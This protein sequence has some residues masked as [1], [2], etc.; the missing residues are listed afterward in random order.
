V[1]QLRLRRAS[2]G[3]PIVVMLE[4]ALPLGASIDAVRVNGRS[5]QYR[6]NATPHDIAPAFETVLA[7]SAVVEIRYAGGAAL[8]AQAKRALPADRSLGLRLLDWR[9]E[10]NR[11]VATVEGMGDQRFRVRTPLDL[12]VID[13][14]TLADRDG[15]FFTI[16]VSLGRETQRRR[17]ILAP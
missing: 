11:F 3:K 2:G 6:R 5:V 15:E 16:A 8:V 12:R 17:V 7:D 14:G 1:L 4:P 13:G 9:L 10:Q